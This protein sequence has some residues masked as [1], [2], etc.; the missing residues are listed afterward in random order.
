MYN[1]ADTVESQDVHVVASVQVRQYEGQLWH[2]REVFTKYFDAQLTEVK[3]TKMSL[4]H[5]VEAKIV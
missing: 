2:R 3:F 5:D 1:V 4:A